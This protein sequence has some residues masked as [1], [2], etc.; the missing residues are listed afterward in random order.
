MNLHAARSDAVLVPE[1]SMLGNAE[2]VRMA[3]YAIAVTFASGTG[4]ERLHRHASHMQESAGF[5][6]A[7]HYAR[8][9]VQVSATRPDL[10][11]NREVLPV[12]GGISSQIP[13]M[14]RK[15]RAKGLRM[16]IHTS[17]TCAGCSRLA[18]S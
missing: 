9:C 14:P 10:T 17:A 7:A 3:A 12:L 1:A 8:A 13:R 6:K 4:L 15:A 11:S 16:I 5:Q 18:I 2:A